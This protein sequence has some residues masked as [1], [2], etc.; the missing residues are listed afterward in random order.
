[1]SPQDL[2]DITEII[3]MLGFQVTLN[4]HV[5]YINLNIFS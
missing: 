1:M 4:H 2:K 5:I 3:N